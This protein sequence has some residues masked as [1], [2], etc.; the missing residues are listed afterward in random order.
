MYFT[1]HSAI[2]NLILTTLFN[3]SYDLSV[4]GGKGAAATTAEIEVFMN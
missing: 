3:N 2:S 4:R 1:A